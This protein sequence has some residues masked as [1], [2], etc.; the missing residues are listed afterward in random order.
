MGEGLLL[1]Q[2]KKAVVAFVVMKIIV[3]RSCGGNLHPSV[4]PARKP[5]RNML[6]RNTQNSVHHTA[7]NSLQTTFWTL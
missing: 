5:Q 6:K 4:W 1:V 7:W 2:R 3:I